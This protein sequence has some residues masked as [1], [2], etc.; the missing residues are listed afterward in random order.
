M[1]KRLVERVLE[2]AGASPFDE[3]IDYM[4]EIKDQAH[5]ILTNLGVPS[6]RCRIYYS[7]RPKKP[8]FHDKRASNKTP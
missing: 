8:F 2:R 6:K 7:R 1:S 5:V 4:C 3:I